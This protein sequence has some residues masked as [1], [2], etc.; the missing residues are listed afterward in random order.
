MSAHSALKRLKWVGI[1]IGFSILLFQAYQGFLAFQNQAL[2]FHNILSIPFTIAI[3]MLS[4]PIQV[5]S[6]QIILSALGHKVHIFELFHVYVIS[7]LPRYI[8]GSFW[9]YITRS[10][11]LLEKFSTPPDTAYF[12]SLIEFLIGIL[13]LVIVSL[14][15]LAFEEGF[16]L[17]L[18]VSFLLLSASILL[19]ILLKITVRQTIKFKIRGLTIPFSMSSYSIERWLASIL[20][21]SMNMFLYGLGLNLISV[22]FLG[23]KHSFFTELSITFPLYF[24]LSYLI[25]FLIFIFPSGLGIREATLSFLLTANLGYTQQQAS[26][27]A[28]IFRL[29]TLAAEI[30]WVLLI[31]GHKSINASKKS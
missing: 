1:L 24:C 28:V 29:C 30:I 23:N 22:S 9:G 19:G 3:I 26:G 16:L 20:L 18:F 15:S 25:G 10:A 11:S 13:A 21:I 4:F 27:I 14:I 17:T 8:P 31:S 7:F 12:S 5:F 6:Y 2:V